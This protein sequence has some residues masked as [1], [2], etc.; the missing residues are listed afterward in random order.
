MLLVFFFYSYINLLIFL[1]SSISFLWSLFH[2]LMWINIF[3]FSFISMSFLIFSMVPDLSSHVVKRRRGRVE[4]GTTIPVIYVDSGW[5]EWPTTLHIGYLHNSQFSAVFDEYP[6]A[7]RCSWPPEI[8]SVPEF[9]Y[10]LSLMSDISS[11]SAME[12]KNSANS[13]TFSSSLFGN[14]IDF[15]KN[16]RARGFAHWS[17]DVA[18]IVSNRYQYFRNFAYIVVQF[19]MNWYR[20]SSSFLITS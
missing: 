3:L 11:G 9:H 5:T 13:R 1:M 4:E 6:A 10:P 8:A 7:G 12:F 2:F 18:S 16:C 15:R 17:L 19:F 14:F 20:C